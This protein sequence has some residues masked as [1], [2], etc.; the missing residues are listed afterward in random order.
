MKMKIKMRQ[1]IIPVLLL[2]VVACSQKSS[3]DV[4]VVDANSKI[5]IAN[6]IDTVSYMIGQSMGNS[7]RRD[8]RWDTILDRD[9][10]FRGIFDAFMRKDSL[11]S[12]EEGD[13]KM[14]V[15][16]QKLQEKFRAEQQRQMAEEKAKV[17]EEFKDYRKECEN[18]L[19]ENKERDEVNTTETGLQYE[20]LKKGK[21]AIPRATDKVKVNYKG[22]LID[23]TVFDRSDEG[24]PVQF[25]VDGVIPGWSEALQMMP[26]GSK[27]KLYIPQEL[28]YGDQQ[29]G[30]TIKPFSTLIFDVELVEIVE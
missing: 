20:I 5:E 13:I 17:A 26:V 15:F 16:M 3:D 25:Q 12:A 29:A 30:E 6:E 4:L 19:A 27:W 7:L 9:V 10:F 1:L 24:K 22:T 18:F 11:I 14:R 2:F 28:A 8:P 23:G 21:G